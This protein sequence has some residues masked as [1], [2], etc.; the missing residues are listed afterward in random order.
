[1]QD[2][3]LIVGHTWSSFDGWGRE[4]LHQLFE[5]PY[6]DEEAQRGQEV[7]IGN[8]YA[9]LVITRGRYGPWLGDVGAGATVGALANVERGASEHS[10]GA[11]AGVE[12]RCRHYLG[13][14]GGA[15]LCPGR[16]LRWVTDVLEEVAHGDD[17]GGMG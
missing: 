8:G 13:I 4:E 14:E 5:A 7:V 1:M 12:V 15:S 9:A 6:N 2:G 17:V 10:G 11:F 3:E 16:A